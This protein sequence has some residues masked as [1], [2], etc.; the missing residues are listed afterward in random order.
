[1]IQNGNKNV[2]LL[3]YTIYIFGSYF[4]TTVIVNISDNS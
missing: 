2:E 3:L 4:I 1:M